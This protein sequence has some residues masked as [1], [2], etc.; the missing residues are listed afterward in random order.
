ML[1]FGTQTR[2]LSELFVYVRQK[3]DWRKADEASFRIVNLLK[4]LGF[5]LV[6]LHA[7][8][9]V[10]PSCRTNVRATTDISSEGFHFSDVGEQHGWKSYMR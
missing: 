6:C 5:S 8:A 1:L 4:R 10:M 2:F 9:T 3:I 7:S